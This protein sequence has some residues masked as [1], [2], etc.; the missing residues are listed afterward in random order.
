MLKLRDIMTRDVLTIDPN[1]SIRDAME[2]L[3]NRH[4]SGAP[5]TAGRRVVG[6]I[7]LT[8]LAEFAASLPG[9][10]TE[11]QH[12]SDEDAT[13]IPI[14][15]EGDPDAVFFTEMWSDAGAD[16]VGRFAAVAGPEWNV[17]EE[18]TVSEAM[19]GDVHALP[20]ETDVLVAAAVMTAAGLHRVLVMK[21]RRLLG[22]VSLTDIAKAAGA[23]KLSPRTY[24]FG[25]AAD[26]DGRGRISTRP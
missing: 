6:V 12:E 14:D 18:H 23:H 5:V 10:P 13:E 17:L 21:G 22:I 8:D 25:H 24:V 4:I 2:L 1:L 19:T 16:V 20:P 26:F 9:A 15:L 3:A 11:R 7:S